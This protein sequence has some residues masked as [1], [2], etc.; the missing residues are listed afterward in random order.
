MLVILYNIIILH[1]ADC[2]EKYGT[3]DKDIGS[4]DMF[5]FYKDLFS[6]YHA[7]DV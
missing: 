1:I 5:F 4:K 6:T 2:Y 7:Y 3:V